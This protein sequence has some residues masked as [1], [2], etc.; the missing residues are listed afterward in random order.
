MRLIYNPIE[1]ISKQLWNIIFKTTQYWRM[2]LKNKLSCWRLKIDKKNYKASNVIYLMLKFE[3][4]KKS[5]RPI[6]NSI[7][8]K[9]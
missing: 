1:K 9:L 2:K 8:N 3:M 5:M 4:K 7:K 6:Y